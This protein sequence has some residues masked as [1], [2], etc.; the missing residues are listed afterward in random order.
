[1]GIIQ[2]VR[3]GYQVFLTKNEHSLD[4]GLVIFI[5]RE[6]NSTRIISI[7]VNVPEAV[8]F[9]VFSVLVFADQ[10]HQRIETDL[11]RVQ[12]GLFHPLKGRQ[13]VC[14]ISFHSLCLH[15]PVS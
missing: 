2:N 8:F 10:V 15:N 5:L 3:G 9:A 4:V 7:R 11:W 12:A 6:R 14:N 1:M 13:S